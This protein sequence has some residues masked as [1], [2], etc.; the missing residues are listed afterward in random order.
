MSTPACPVCGRWNDPTG[1]PDAH[2]GGCPNTGKPYPGATLRK[3][4][5][6]SLGE[7]MLALIEVPVDPDDDPPEAWLTDGRIPELA[8]V[9]IIWSRRERVVAGL[10]RL[11]TESATDVPEREPKR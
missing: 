7:V 2:S 1:G 10:Y 5:A 3:P 4:E 9:E 6:A 11:T 8:G